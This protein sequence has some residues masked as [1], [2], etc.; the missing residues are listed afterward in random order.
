MEIQ[1]G[2]IEKE[3]EKYNQ[4]K[5]DKEEQERHEQERRKKYIYLKRSTR[6]MKG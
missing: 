3:I 6:K 2:K 1:V 4:E 5:A